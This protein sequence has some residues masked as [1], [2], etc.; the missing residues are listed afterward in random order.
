GHVPGCAEIPDTSRTRYSGYDTIIDS[1]TESDERPGHCFA[2]K[3]HRA[4][5]QRQRPSAVGVKMVVE[6]VAPNDHVV[7][8]KDQDSASSGHCTGIPRG[9]TF[10]FL[11]SH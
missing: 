7:V 2:R 5:H 1:L 4:D 11:Q 8:D 6:E 10:R 9:G 3:A